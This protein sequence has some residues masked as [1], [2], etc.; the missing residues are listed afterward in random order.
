MPPDVSFVRVRSTRVLRRNLPEFRASYHKLP[1]HNSSRDQ[2]A[3][4]SFRRLARPELLAQFLAL[5][6]VSEQGV[7]QKGLGLSIVGPLE[8]VVASRHV[9]DQ[10]FHPE[11]RVAPISHHR[12]FLHSNE[13]AKQIA[14]F[15]LHADLEAPKPQA[16]Q[17]GLNPP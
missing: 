4:A 7:S 14:S 6:Q 11:Q 17:V 12:V 5:A 16:L 9:L 13:I 15:R 10:V 2:A 1:A 8:L 3:G